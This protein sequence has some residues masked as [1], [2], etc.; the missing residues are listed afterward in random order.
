[1]SRSNPDQIE[2]MHEVI[3]LLPVRN[4]VLFPNIPTQL[5]VGHDESRQL[6]EDAVAADEIFSTLMGENVEVRRR[7]IEENA[8]EVKNLDV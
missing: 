4:V 3:S 5:L 2:G 8:L 7:F 1:M 6:V